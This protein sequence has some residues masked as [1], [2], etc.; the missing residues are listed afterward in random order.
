M[1]KG[2]HDAIAGTGET[3]SDEYR[4]VRDDGEVRFVFDRGYISRDARGR[5]LRIVGSMVD[6]TNQKIADARLPQAE[7]LDALGKMTGGVAQHFTKPPH[8]NMGQA[9]LL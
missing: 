9:R 3:W 6:V 4:F 7:K 1:V 2:F 8:V 5:G